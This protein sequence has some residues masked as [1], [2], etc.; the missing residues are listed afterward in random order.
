M[1]GSTV[2]KFN[3]LVRPGAP[4]LIEEKSSKNL[5]DRFQKLE[6]KKPETIKCLAA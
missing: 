6:D 2:S 5:H 3:P 1:D 4:P